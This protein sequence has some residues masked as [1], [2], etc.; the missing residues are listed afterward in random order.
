MKT[1]LVLSVLVL[2]I[3][4]HA[5][6]PPAAERLREFKAVTEARDLYKALKGRTAEAIQVDADGNFTVI[7]EGCAVSVQVEIYDDGGP[8]FVPPLKATVT[9]STCQ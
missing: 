8:M 3:A 5:A 2:N 4:V 6:L 9:Q 7:A 1:I